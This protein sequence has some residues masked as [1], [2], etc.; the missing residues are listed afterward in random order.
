MQDR[1][2]EQPIITPSNECATHR[3]EVAAQGRQVHT[4]AERGDD[5]DA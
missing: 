1:R 2:S 5:A 3:R 4:A